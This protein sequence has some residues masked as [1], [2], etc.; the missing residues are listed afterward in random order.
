M[1]HDCLLAYKSDVCR[2]EVYDLILIENKLKEGNF[3][4]TFKLKEVGCLIC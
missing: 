2:K 3:K 4:I 1:W